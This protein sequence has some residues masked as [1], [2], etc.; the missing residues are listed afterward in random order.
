MV[1][2]VV[3]DTLPESALMVVDPAATAVATAV[4]ASIVAAAV[5]EELQVSGAGVHAVLSVI[6]PV[7]EN[8]TGESPICIVE[9]PGEIVSVLRTAGPTVTVKVAVFTVDPT[10]TVAVMTAV[11][12]DTEVPPPVWFT[13]KTAALEELH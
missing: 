12:C 5:L 9:L 1:S 10:L 3:A 2:V 6:V 11:P 7:A 8:V 4:V 13:L